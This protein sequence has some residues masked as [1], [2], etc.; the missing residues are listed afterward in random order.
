[1]IRRFDG[2]LRFE[3]IPQRPF[4]VRLAGAHPDLADQNVL[5]RHGVLALHSQLIGP[6]G[7]QFGQ[8]HF[9]GTVGAGGPGRVLLL[10]PFDRNGDRFAGLGRAPNG[11][12]HVAL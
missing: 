8:L 7:R 4:H 5:D 11:Q 12:R 9:P 10:L 3:R 2:L 6:A 1:M